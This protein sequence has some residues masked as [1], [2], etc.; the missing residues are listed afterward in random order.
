MSFDEQRGKC[1][2]LVTNDEDACFPS[3]AAYP[4]E[5]GIQVHPIRFERDAL[6]VAAALSVG[7]S[8]AA[9]RFHGLISGGG[10]R[11]TA[12]PERRRRFVRGIRRRMRLKGQQHVVYM[13]LLNQYVGIN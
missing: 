7:R 9:A 6:V 1:A 10:V 13:L 4:R 3:F 2:A 8:T 12:L 5:N 11:H